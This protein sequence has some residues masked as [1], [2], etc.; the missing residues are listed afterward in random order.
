MNLKVL[1]RM[2]SENVSVNDKRHILS[3]I[4]NHMTRMLLDYEAGSQY[5]SFETFTCIF[6]YLV[7]RRPELSQY[8]EI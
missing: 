3:K 8:F 5:D 4:V 1:F 7:E 6:D 2:M